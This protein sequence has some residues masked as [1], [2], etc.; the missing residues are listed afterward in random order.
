MKNH[1]SINSKSKHIFATFAVSLLPIVARA[2]AN[3]SLAGETFQGIVFYILRIIRTLI[4]IL[5]ALAFI[6]FF[7]GL[8]KFILKSDD[9]KTRENG[10]NY[11][12]WGVLALFILVSFRVI[13]SFISNDLELGPSIIAPH[14]PTGFTPSVTTSGSITL[15]HGTQ[16]P[17]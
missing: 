17:I 12:M 8:S 9:Q 16:V 13:I 15:R 5:W 7:W 2:Q 4:P 11:M 10:K 1:H 6:I 3:F 14:L